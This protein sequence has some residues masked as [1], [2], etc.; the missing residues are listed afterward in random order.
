MTGNPVV[1][2]DDDDD[3]GDTTDLSNHTSR[4]MTVDNPGVGG[5]NTDRDAG[6]AAHTGEVVASSDLDDAAMLPRDN[7]SAIATSTS[8]SPEIPESDSGATMDEERQ[9]HPSV[10]ADS[11]ASPSGK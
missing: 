7:R 3:D 1:V 11:I 5:K 2:D 6:G 8:F 9:L 4:P 10:Q